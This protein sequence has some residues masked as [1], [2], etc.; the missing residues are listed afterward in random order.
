[1]N[2]TEFIERLEKALRQRGADDTEDIL[3]EYEQHFAFKLADGCTEEETAARLGPPELLASQFCAGEG[4]G[5]GGRK[6]VTVIGLCFSHMFAGFFFILLF[7]WEL[8]MG[9]FSLACAAAAV[10]LFGDMNIHGLIPP[11]PYWCGAVMGLSLAALAVLSAVG[12]VYFWKFLRQLTRSYGRFCRNALASASGTAVLPP[13]EIYPQIPA[14]A[15]R[16]LRTAALVSLAMFAACFVLGII[17]CMLSSGALEF[18]HAWGWFG[19][20]A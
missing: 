12:C 17:V 7:T 6:L 10:C 19:Y 9:V 1:M 4:K 20:A 3:A 8:I 11:M 18:W 15:K 14:K 2:K 5:G 16:A 13:L